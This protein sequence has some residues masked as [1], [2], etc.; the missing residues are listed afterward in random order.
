MHKVYSVFFT[1]YIVLILNSQTAKLWQLN[2][3]SELRVN[4]VKYIGRE[5]EK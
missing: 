5:E 3:L 4:I 1:G 2:T